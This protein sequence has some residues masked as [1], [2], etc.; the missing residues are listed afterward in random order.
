MAFVAIA[1]F[2]QQNV[3]LGYAFKFVRMA[4]L[5]LVYVFGAWGLLAG[6]GL[7]L[8]LVLTNVT[9]LG[10]YRYAYPLIPFNPKAMI[11]LLF[12]VKKDDFSGEE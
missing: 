9:V 3:E 7:F 12:R 10:R 6:A 4:M 2:A 1:N 11:R 5:G 8:L